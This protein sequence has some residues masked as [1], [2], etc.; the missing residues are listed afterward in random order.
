MPNLLYLIWWLL[1]LF[2][3]TM[4]LWAKLEQMSNRNKQQNPGDFFRQGIFVTIGVLISMWLDSSVLPGL[5]PAIFP[6][7]IPMGFFQVILLPV[8]LYLMALIIGP[9]KEI[10][11]PSGSSKTKKPG[12]TKRGR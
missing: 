1:P 7:S 5:I 10:L 8:V 3:F 12:G 4:A 11:I 2:F 9:S 6:P